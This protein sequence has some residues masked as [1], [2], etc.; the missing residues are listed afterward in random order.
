[1]SGY[2]Q[3]AQKVASW[4]F[5]ALVHNWQ[6]RGNDPADEDIQADL[7]EAFKYLDR[8]LDVDSARIALMGFCKGGTFAFFAARQRPSLIGVAIFHGFC[9]RKASEQHLLQPFQLVNEMHSPMLFMHGTKDSQAPIESMRDLVVALEE[10]NGSVSLHEYQ[11]VE[12]GFAV[13][14]HPGYEPN[15]A[16]DSFRR[17]RAFFAELVS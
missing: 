15:S 1:M 5:H 12:H 14:T 13:T 3:I 2:I 16:N 4:G 11:G 10:R 7:A 6:V 8:H 17:A 9:R